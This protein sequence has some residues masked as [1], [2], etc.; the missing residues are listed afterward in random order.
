MREKEIGL[1]SPMRRRSP[2]AGPDPEDVRYEN[3]LRNCPSLIE[4]YSEPRMTLSQDPARIIS[5]RK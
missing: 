4:M 2:A 3:S 1:D 5:Q